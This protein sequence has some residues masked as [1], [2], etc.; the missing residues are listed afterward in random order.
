M[1]TVTA[2]EAVKDFARVLAAVEHG[3]EIAISRK[4]ATVARLLPST[5]WRG[6]RPK[7]GTVV[8]EPMDVPADA[9][10]ALSGA[11]LAQW[12]L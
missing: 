10:R 3:E 1:K 6:A 4:G 5:P 11:E 12:G 8:D 9:L 2:E 7:V